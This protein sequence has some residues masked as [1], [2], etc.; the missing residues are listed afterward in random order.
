MLPVELVVQDPSLLALP[1][2]EDGPDANEVDADVSD[3]VDA[4][5]YDASRDWSAYD[6]L[7]PWADADILLTSLDDSNRERFTALT[8]AWLVDAYLD[9]ERVAAILDALEMVAAV[10]S[11]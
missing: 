6:D 5:R 1:R 2:S 9:A 10:G 4:L 3:F 8:S 11:R 7:R